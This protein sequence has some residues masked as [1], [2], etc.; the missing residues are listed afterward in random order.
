MPSDDMGDD[1]M[2]SSESGSGGLPGPDALHPQRVLLGL[3][4]LFLTDSDGPGAGEPASPP[5]TG[6]E[7]PLPVDTTGEPLAVERGFAFVDVCGF[8]LYCDRHG[9]HAAIELLTRFR[10][11][12]RDVAGRR[13]VRVAK[14]LGDG[15]MLVGTE[16]APLVAGVAELVLR[17]ARIGLDLHAGVAAGK[18][19]L[20]E[21]DDYVG[22][23][24]NLAARL[25]DAAEPGEILA[26]GLRDEL[27]EWVRARETVTVAV[28]GV[29]EVSGVVSVAADDEVA[30]QFGLRPPPGGRD[31]AAA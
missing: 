22:R 17:N 26:C 20:F 14:W 4:S 19:L 15:V 18:V 1:R 2:T 29:G 12:V 24:V 23:P 30:A 27:P 25:C 16:D 10:E 21:G 9:E 7:P 3:R 13:G 31:G 5:G 8:T 6:V 11:H 28:S